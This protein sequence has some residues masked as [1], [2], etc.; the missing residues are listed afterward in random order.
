V[1]VTTDNASN[2]V[3]SFKK[4]HYEIPTTMFTENE[5]EMV[6]DFCH[7]DQD[8]DD[9][10]A[11]K[12]PGVQGRPGPGEE[13][14]EEEEEEGEK[15]EEEEVVVDSDLDIDV[16]EHQEPEI[17]DLDSVLKPPPAEVDAQTSMYFHYFV[18]VL[19]YFI[20]LL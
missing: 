18:L 19:I 13:N 1:Q 6:E 3:K 4:F 2:F 9:E 11:Q 15:E 8:D 12:G 7:D 14:N 16:E 20:I 17:C 10:N 5:I